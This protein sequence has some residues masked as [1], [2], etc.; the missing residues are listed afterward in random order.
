LCLYGSPEI[1]KGLSHLPLCNPKNQIK[2]Q[3]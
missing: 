2:K 1:R 3:S